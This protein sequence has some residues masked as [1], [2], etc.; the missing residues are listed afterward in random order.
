VGPLRCAAL[1][2]LTRA[3]ARPLPTPPKR[4]HKGRITPVLCCHSTHLTYTQP[5]SAASMGGDAM[6][7]GE[8][9]AEGEPT[10]RFKAMDVSLEELEDAAKARLYLCVEENLLLLC[11]YMCPSYAIL[12]AASL[13]PLFRG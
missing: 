8:D 13:P 1:V 3:Q 2:E 6:G 5:H 11:S 4:H 10:V 9:H 12:L 7:D